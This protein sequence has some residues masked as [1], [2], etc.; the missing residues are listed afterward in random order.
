[1]TK[2]GKVPPMANPKMI[3]SGQPSTKKIPVKGSHPYVKKGS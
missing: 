2:A 1:M 3:S